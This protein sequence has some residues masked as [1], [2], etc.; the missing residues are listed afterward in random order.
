MTPTEER[1]LT[2]PATFAHTYLA[3]VGTAGVTGFVAGLGTGLPQAAGML[4]IFLLFGAVTGALFA[5]PIAVLWFCLKRHINPTL[6]AG[7][8]YSALVGVILG[9]WMADWQFEATMPSITG[10]A[11]GLC[12]GFLYWLTG[13]MC[14]CRKPH[15][16]GYLEPHMG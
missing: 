4:V 5:I 13:K 10:G 16:T 12:G 14:T 7:L 11:M 1:N 9:F 2:F 6:P 8:L 15:Q 3:Y